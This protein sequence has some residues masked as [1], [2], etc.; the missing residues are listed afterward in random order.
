MS[1]QFGEIHRD[2]LLRLAEHLERGRLSHEKFDYRYVHSCCG[3]SGC[4]IGEMPA[5]WPDRFYMRPY[6]T[7]YHTVY[8]Q[9]GLHTYEA[10]A[11]F[12]AIPVEES[13]FLFSSNYNNLDSCASKEEVAAHIRSFVTKKCL[14]V[15]IPER[16]LPTHAR[17][18]QESLGVEALCGKSEVVC[19]S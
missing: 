6:S 11:Q 18:T 10:A 9:N 14:E 3:T 19:T 15:G 17:L 2:R 4:A 13:R 12:F 8:N 7:N 16:D 1:N 5:I